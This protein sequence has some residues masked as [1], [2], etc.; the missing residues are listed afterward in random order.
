MFNIRP[1]NDAA[2]SRSIG[3]HRA[4]GFSD[5]GVLKNGGFK[6]GRW[7]DVVSM[8]KLLGDGATTLPEQPA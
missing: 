2:H 7:P 3:V 5:V 8:T 1:G 4:Q 6:L